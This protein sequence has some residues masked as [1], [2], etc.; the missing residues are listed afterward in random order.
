MNSYVREIPTGR[1]M[2][3]EVGDD[4]YRVSDLIH[5]KT[6][7]MMNLKREVDRLA[8]SELSQPSVTPELT[9]QITQIK[10]QAVDLAVKGGKELA[11]GMQAVTD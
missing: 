3:R 8:N 5:R 2:R 11:E 7:E 9:T 6:E 1:Q 4:V 10:L